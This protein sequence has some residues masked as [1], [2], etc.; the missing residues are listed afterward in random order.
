MKQRTATTEP[1]SPP[2]RTIWLKAAI[3]IALALT[4]VVVLAV[5]FGGLSAAPTGTVLPS[6]ANKQESTTPTVTKP[7]QQPSNPLEAVPLAARNRGRKLVVG[8]TDP[9]ISLDPSLATGDGETILAALTCEPLARISVDGTLENR[10]ADSWTIDPTTRAI[11][12]RL[13]SAAEF[14]DGSP[15]RPADIVN[16]YR[17]LFD[18]ERSKHRLPRFPG[19]QTV[20]SEQDELV[21]IF[22]EWA[23]P[24]PFCLT[25]PIAGDS[26]DGGKQIGSGPYR[27]VE[28]DASVIRLTLR[29]SSALQNAEKSIGSIELRAIDSADRSQMLREGLLDIATGTWD[30]RMQTRAVRLPGSQFLTHADQ[31][32]VLLLINPDAPEG[33]NSNGFLPEERMALITACADELSQGWPAE[34]FT[35]EAPIWDR[36]GSR[37]L[38]LTYP[39]DQIGASVDWDGL[40]ARLSEQLA[41]DQVEIKLDPVPL[42][43]LELRLEERSFELMLWPVAQDRIIPETLRPLGSV[44]PDLT[45]CLPVARRTAVDIISQRLRLVHPSAPDDPLAQTIG[46]WYDNIESLTLVEPQT[47][48]QP[49]VSSPEASTEISLPAEAISRTSEVISGLSDGI[50]GSDNPASA[51]TSSALPSPASAASTSS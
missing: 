18:D 42:Q 48:Q 8:F 3:L 13:R 16:S 27:L 46:N 21:F 15:V 9:V 38:T 33:E 45:D 20:E 25:L 23:D 30:L 35:A 19:L 1:A 11:R 7:D 50:G 44:R 34:S 26:A 43:D 39:A 36:L 4:P 12:L 2:K 47:A 17:R 49:G 40:V 37:I 22:A 14:E 10:L 6:S 41:E 29:D 31:T 32:S 28:R 24:D 51:S 5:R